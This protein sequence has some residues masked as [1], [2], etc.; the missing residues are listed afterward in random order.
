MVELP[1]LLF[2]QLQ[3]LEHHLQQPPVGGWNSVEAPSASN[4]GSWVVRKRR[5]AKA[6][7]I[8]ALVSP[9]AKAFSMRHSAKSRRLESGEI[10]GGTDLPGSKD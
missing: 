9:S 4:N 1:N 5:S 10:S 2:D 8:S 6:A 3:L 7:R